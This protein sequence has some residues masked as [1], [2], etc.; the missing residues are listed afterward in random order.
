MQK[1]SPHGFRGFCEVSLRRY[2]LLTIRSQAGAQGARV[3]GV[4]RRGQLRQQR[5][6]ALGEVREGELLLGPWVRTSKNLVP[7]GCLVFCVRIGAGWDQGVARRDGDLR[8]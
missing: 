4:Q 6:P 5:G 1:K 2:C 8:L 3:L 7:Q